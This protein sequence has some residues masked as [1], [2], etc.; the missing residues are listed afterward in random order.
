MDDDGNPQTVEPPQQPAGEDLLLK[1]AIE[2]VTK[3][4]SEVVSN[5]GITRRF[6]T[7]RAALDSADAAQ[8]AEASRLITRVF[9]FAH[10]RI[11]MRR[12]RRNV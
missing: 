7:G 6:Q 4:K 5:S 11:Q 2:V 12:L 9:T 10:L 3:G 8:R 1:K